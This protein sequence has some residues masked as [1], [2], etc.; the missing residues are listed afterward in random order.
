M[1]LFPVYHTV[2]A[3]SHSLQDL[4]QDPLSVWA[5]EVLWRNPRVSYPRAVAPSYR[6]GSLR[7]PFFCHHLC[8][9][10][11]EGIVREWLIG[12]A[13]LE[14]KNGLCHDHFT[15]LVRSSYLGGSRIV[16]NQRG[17]SAQIKSIAD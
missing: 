1:R 2:I 12:C 11:V 15:A 9:I 16:A 8:G 10:K 13:S 4:S 5:T 14:R 7:I 3:G 17:V 6:I